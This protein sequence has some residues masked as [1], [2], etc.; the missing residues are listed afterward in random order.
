MKYLLKVFICLL[1]IFLILKFVIHL[2]DDGHE[3]T[4][5][6]GNFKVTETYNAED[7]NY[8]FELQHNNFDLIFDVTVDYNKAS[9]I[10]DEINYKEIDDYQC[11]MPVFKNDDILIDMMCMKDDI[12]YYAHD[13]DNSSINEYASSMKKYGY[14][15]TDYEDNGEKTNL[16]STT[17]IYQDNILDN[18]YLALENYKGIDLY[19]SDNTTV[20]LFENDVY[21]KPISV[22]T[23]KYYVVADYNSEYSFKIFKVVNIINGTEKEIRSYDE[24]SFDSVVQGVVDGEIYIFDKDAR[25]QYKINLE[26]ETVE[27]VSEDGDIKYYNGKWST[28]SLTDALNEKKFDNYYTNIDGYEKVDKVGKYYYVYEK[29][30]DKYLVYKAYNKKVTEKI[31]L[32]TTSDINSVIYANEYIYFRDD[33]IFYYWSNSGVKKILEDSELEFNDDITLGVYVK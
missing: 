16:S 19:S 12:V 11:V 2:L 25:V 21:K 31:Y 4:Y 17:A 28:M 8:K 18:H 33:T 1:L 23:D 5:N 30:D 32:F 3:I 7:N 27:N 29:Q 20:N 6:V 10:I 24:I 26:N 9:N 13:L 22:F 14:K 15:Q